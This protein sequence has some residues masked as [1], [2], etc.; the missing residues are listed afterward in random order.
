MQ[1][2]H[3]EQEQSSGPDQLRVGLKEVSIAIDGFAPEENLQIT[4]EVANHKQQHHETGH[5]H[6]VFLAE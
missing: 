1:G 5:R 4:G 2:D 6:Y 3:Q